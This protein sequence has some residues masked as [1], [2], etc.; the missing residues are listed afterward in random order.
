MI[1]FFLNIFKLLR[2]VASGIKN[3]PEFRVLLFLLVTLLIGST[4]FYSS[5]EGWSKL[6]ALY[7]SVMTMSTIGT[8]NLV[9][10]MDISKVFTI[11]FTFLSVGI[12]VSINAKIVM[13][14]LSK[15]TEKSL[16]RAEKKS[17]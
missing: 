17:K 5:T 11:I 6:D 8:V 16:R 13:I 9:P 2:A 15:K 12:F 7:F 10:V 4:M 3:D 14:T 1:S